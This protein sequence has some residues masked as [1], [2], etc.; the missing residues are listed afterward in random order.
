[1]TSTRSIESS[2]VARGQRYAVL[3]LDDIALV[4]PQTEMRA[5][6]A[7][8]DVDASE[9]PHSGIGW[10]AFGDRRL[11]V[12]SLTRDLVVVSRRARGRM[13]CAVI[14]VDRW[15]FAL[16]CDEVELVELD[17]STI[18][19]LPDCMLLGG[20]PLLGVVRKD[21]RIGFPTSAARLW[22]LVGLPD[23]AWQ[24]VARRAA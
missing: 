2:P 15:M 21:D 11:P 10:I 12:Y 1:M 19:P 7:A 22:R 20:S 3:K 5:I 24:D 17:E 8:D 6:E 9:P 14:G 18:T 23:E 16:L 13:M 4:L